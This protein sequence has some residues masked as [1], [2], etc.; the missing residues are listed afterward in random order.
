[1]DGSGKEKPVPI[2]NEL[3]GIVSP[4]DRNGLMDGGEQEVGAWDSV[5]LDPL[6]EETFIGNLHHRFKR[7]HIYVSLLVVIIAL[8]LII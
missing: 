8:V 5:L 4:M 6:T 2:E 1:M 3:E 7:D